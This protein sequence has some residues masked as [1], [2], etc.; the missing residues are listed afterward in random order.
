M[1]DGGGGGDGG[2]AQRSKDE[3]ARR[4]AAIDQINAYFGMTP[5]AQTV[6]TGRTVI[7]GHQIAT[8]EHGNAIYSPSGVSVTNAPNP[9]IDTAAANA[10]G[11]TAL[12]D[13][14]R[15]DVL[16]LNLAKLTDYA[17]EA[18]R[19]RKFGIA[20]KGQLGG[21]VD[22]DSANAF[23][24]KY[25]DQTNVASAN[26]DAAGLDL[27]SSD[28]ASRLRLIQDI[29]AGG[30]VNTG[31]QNSINS[32][33]LNADNAAAG[34]Q[35]RVLSNGFGDLATQYAYGA[36][37]SGRADAAKTFASRTLAGPSNKGYS[38]TVSK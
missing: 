32:L 28:E 31:I 35:G 5:N 9:L 12:Y 27:K 19:Q 37:L 25:T 6:E 10:T 22:I 15:G 1:P 13:K 4:A 14:T 24:R 17:T 33:K 20:R 2:A 8:G 23:R 3:N 11:R 18:E 7:P 34:E 30:D 29:N 26:A 38:G 21:S 16:D 36:D